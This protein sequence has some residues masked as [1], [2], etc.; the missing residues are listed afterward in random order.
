[1]IGINSGGGVGASGVFLT[2]FDIIGS[3]DHSYMHTTN[4]VYPTIK[5]KKKNNKQ[6]K[7]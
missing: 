2:N 5:C 4:N 3:L 7:R 6:E 1:M